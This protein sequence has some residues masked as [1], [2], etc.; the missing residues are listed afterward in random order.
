MGIW[1]ETTLCDGCNRCIRACTYDAVELVDGIAR[2][3]ERCTLCQ[4]CLKACRNNAVCTDIEP[5]TIPDFSDWKGIWVVAEHQ[6]GSLAPV[7][8]ELLGKAVDLACASNENVSAILLG[9][10]VAAM[11]DTLAAHGAGTVYLADHE[12]LQDYDTL[13]YTA[14]IEKMVRKERPSILLL[15]ATLQGRDLAPRVS[16]RVGAG[17][18]A[19]CTELSIDPAEGILLQTRPAFGGNVMATIANR[20]SRP[21]MATVRPGV[22]T[23]L[24]ASDNSSVII[25]HPVGVDETSQVIQV[26]E[27]VKDTQARGD[28]SDAAVLVAGGRGVGSEQGFAMLRQLADILGGDV[29]GTRIAMEQGFIPRESQVGQT[30]KTVRPEIFIACGISGAI[31]HTAGMMGS[32]YIIAINADPAAPIFSIANW[33]IVGDV[34]E[35]V[36]ELIR[37]LS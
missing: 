1:I 37:Q 9:H 10:Q 26:L 23:P 21:Q 33:G 30:G 24:P 4:A 2:I 17:L 35:I 19:D 11:A 27:T 36:P 32:R 20:Y 3:T 5:V 12:T 13:A 15:G 18:T 14:V 16:R 6:G 29:A 34:H 28:I 7:T 8:L 22:M 25:Q 31:Q